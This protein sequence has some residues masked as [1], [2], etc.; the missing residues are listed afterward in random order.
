MA[1]TRCGFTLI[2]LIVVL[3]ILGVVASVVAPALRGVDRTAPRDAAESLAAALA[4]A[5]GL[6]VRSSGRVLLHL[7]L[8]SGAY[9]IVG[10]SM[11]SGRDTAIAGML[12]VS[13]G[14]RLSGGQ[15]GWATLT[16]DALGRASGRPIVLERGED[17]WAVAV[18]PWTAVVDV[19]R[20]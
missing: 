5:G 4:K 17:R 11:R 20:R 6:A 1:R 14:A 2:E 15:D 9:T 8:S 3:M 7:E 18:D 16:F 12:R 19:R 10:Q 13:G